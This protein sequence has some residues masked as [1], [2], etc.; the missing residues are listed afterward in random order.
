VGE[1]GLGVS[2]GA[3][4]M[5]GRGVGVKKVAVG[6]GVRVTVRVGVGAS[7]RVDVRVDVRVGVTVWVGVIVWVPVAVAVR[8]GV[9]VGVAEGGWVAAMPSMVKLPEV[10]HSCPTKT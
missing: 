3:G 5:D 8:V 10:F 4:V 1:A 2:V 9:R 6:E 7:V